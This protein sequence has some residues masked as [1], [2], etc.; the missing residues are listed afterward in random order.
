[1]NLLTVLIIFALIAT[2]VSL[3]AGLRSMGKGGNY[4][5]QHADEFMSARIISQGIALLLLIVAVFLSA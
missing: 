2:I 3:A 4:D 1:M 5:I